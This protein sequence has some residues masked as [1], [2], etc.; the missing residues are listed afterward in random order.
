MKRYSEEEL[1][2]MSEY[3]RDRLYENGKM[4]DDDWQRWQDMQGEMSY[5]AED[6][7]RN[8]SKY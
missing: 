1:I 4:D 5:L 6:F 3:Q 7:I 8:E 2:E